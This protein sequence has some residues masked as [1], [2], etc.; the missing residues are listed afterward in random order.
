[1]EVVP[2]YRRSAWVVRAVGIPRSSGRCPVRYRRLMAESGYSRS[3]VA[4]LLPAVLALLAEVGGSPE[5]QNY[6]TGYFGV[7]AG[8]DVA[9]VGSDLAR[10]WG[11]HVASRPPS[12][13]TGWYG[14]DGRYRTAKVSPPISP[15]ASP[16][17]NYATN[18]TK[19]PAATPASSSTAA[20]GVPPGGRTLPQR[21]RLMSENG[22][23]VGK[24]FCWEGNDREG[25]SRMSSNVT[26]WRLSAGSGKPIRQVANELGIYDS[27][28]NLKPEPHTATAVPRPD[29]YQPRT[30]LPNPDRRFRSPL[31]NH[32]SSITNSSKPPS[33]AYP[34]R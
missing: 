18:G 34:H 30:S 6:E 13:L 16:D 29:R 33:L 32:G 3:T 7:L 19:A 23:S 22:H 24:E 10:R 8:P 27:T 26:R 31:Q 4:C 20:V 28:N 15:A 5:R 17:P 11:W 25:S 9:W 14:W 21:A 1:M 12:K 2:I